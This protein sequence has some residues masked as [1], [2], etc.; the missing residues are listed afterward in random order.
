MQRVQ[1]VREFDYMLSAKCGTTVSLKYTAG[2]D[3]T[4]PTETLTLPPGGDQQLQTLTVQI[5]DDSVAEGM[6]GFSVVLGIQRG[7]TDVI[8]GEIPTTTVTIVDNDGMNYSCGYNDTTCILIFFVFVGI[9]IGF[10]Q[11]RHRE[12]EGTGG[13]PVTVQMLS[14]RLETSITVRMF[15]V[16]GVAT[17]K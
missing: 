9:A 3:F 16:N 15:T 14:G 8:L 4:A 1:P 17:S 11:A 12:S 10:T 6:E 7:D 2:E 13:V 5:I